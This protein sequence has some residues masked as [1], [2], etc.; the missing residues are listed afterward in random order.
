VNIISNPNIKNKYKA[1][2]ILFE[3][4]KKLSIYKLSKQIIESYENFLSN[5][6]S[7]NYSNFKKKAE[8][9]ASNYFLS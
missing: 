6:H 2:N 4:K 7:Y 3:T 1:T 9:M 8:S 5:L